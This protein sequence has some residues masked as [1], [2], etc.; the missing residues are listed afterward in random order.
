MTALFKQ[1]AVPSIHQRLQYREDGGNGMRWHPKVIPWA[2]N[3]QAKSS[4]TYLM[5]S[6]SGMLC[7]PSDR[8]LNEFKSCR[9]FEAGIDYDLITQHASTLSTLT[10]P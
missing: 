10:T 4:S 8:T 7:L 2:L 3:I 1:L 5:M 9:P 6:E